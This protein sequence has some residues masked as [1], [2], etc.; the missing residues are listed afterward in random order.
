MKDFDT[1]TFPQGS[2]NNYQD[3]YKAVFFVFFI[4]YHVTANIK[5]NSTF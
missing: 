3:K 5:A 4:N 2:K 1:G